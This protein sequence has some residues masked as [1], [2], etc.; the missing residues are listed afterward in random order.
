MVANGSGFIIERSRM[1]IAG[2][3]NGCEC[4]GQIVTKPGRHVR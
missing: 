2:D 4:L 3:S 1:R